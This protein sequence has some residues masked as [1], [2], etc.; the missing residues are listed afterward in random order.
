MS[1]EILQDSFDPLTVLCRGLYFH[2]CFTVGETEAQA[3]S[4]DQDPHPGFSPGSFLCVP[5]CQ[6]T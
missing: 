4:H 5:Q 3:G 6:V 1:Q 2:L